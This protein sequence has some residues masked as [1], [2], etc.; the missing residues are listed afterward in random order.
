MGDST[1]HPIFSMLL[2]HT[3]SGSPVDGVAIGPCFG[4]CANNMGLKAV[5]ND[6]NTFPR[7]LRIMRI[8]NFFGTQSP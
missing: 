7:M 8:S 2:T 3:T 6:M 1:T 5:T 4:I